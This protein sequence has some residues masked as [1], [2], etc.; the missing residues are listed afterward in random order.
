ML[1]YNMTLRT[2]FACEKCVV[3]GE[4]CPQSKLPLITCSF[5][6]RMGTNDLQ[7]LLA[8]D[9]RNFMS[10]VGREQ[11]WRRLPISTFPGAPTESRA[12]KRCFVVRPRSSHVESD[13]PVAV[14]PEHRHRARVYPRHQGG[15][16]VAG[17]ARHPNSLQ[18]AVWRGWTR[19]ISTPSAPPPPPSPPHTT[20]HTTQH[21]KT[22]TSHSGSR[23][24][25]HKSRSVVLF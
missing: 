3:R 4:C 15:E 23:L 12:S 13:C 19:H 10:K 7:N 5:K 22:T 24:P 14:G 1:R 6:I 9:F 20:H 17:V 21:T 2:S 16:G 11:N 25:T 8:V 18:A